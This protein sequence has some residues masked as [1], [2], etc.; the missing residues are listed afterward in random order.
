MVEYEAEKRY[1]TIKET[2]IANKEKALYIRDFLLI[3]NE[4]NIEKD[5]NSN[6]TSVLPKQVQLNAMQYYLERESNII[7]YTQSYKNEASIIKDSLPSYIW[8]LS[9]LETKK[10]GDFVCM[11]ATT[12]FRGSK[13]VAWYAEELN[14]PFGPWKFKGLPGLILEVYNINDPFIEHWIAKKITYPYEKEV[15][16]KYNNHLPII[17]YKTVV[18]DREIKIQEELQ[19]TQSRAPQGVKTI[20]SKINREG[21]EKEYE[22][23]K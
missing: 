9:S 18:I 13:I 15:E 1:F 8:D 21:I 16:F 11:K 17:K 10:I 20:K 2:L 6:K 4:N 19:R 23:E 14:I 7:Y 22:W 5:K 3:E 12:T